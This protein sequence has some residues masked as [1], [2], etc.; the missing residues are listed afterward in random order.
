LVAEVG[1]PGVGEA[2]EVGL[3]V[4]LVGGDGAAVAGEGGDALVAAKG[5]K[6][7]EVNGGLG[8]FDGYPF[9]VVGEEYDIRIG[10]EVA[11][12]GVVV[13]YAE[14]WSLGVRLPGA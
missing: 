1:G 12:L 14:V 3:G 6:S 5:A 2:G 10:D 7:G 8:D 4:G 13:G 11:V 9:G